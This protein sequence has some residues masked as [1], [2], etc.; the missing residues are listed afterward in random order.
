MAD[1]KF[2]PFRTKTLSMNAHL[3]GTDAIQSSTTALRFDLI[4]GLTAAAV[5]LPKAMA[6]ATASSRLSD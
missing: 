5:V 4:A 2:P 6:Y 1:F 3:T